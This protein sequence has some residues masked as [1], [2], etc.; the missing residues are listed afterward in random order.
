MCLT[1]RHPKLF[2]SKNLGELLVL[3]GSSVSFSFRIQHESQI[4]GAK[5]R[6]LTQKEKCEKR[7]VYWF[8]QH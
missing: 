7:K 5:L 1:N 8:I 3:S 6:I 4:S 2:L